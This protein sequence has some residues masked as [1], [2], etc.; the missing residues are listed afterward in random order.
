[1][2]RCL[3]GSEPRREHASIGLT[4]FVCGCDNLILTRAIPIHSDAF[5]AEFKGKAVDLVNISYSCV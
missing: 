3:T 2:T 4:S 5:A 1:L